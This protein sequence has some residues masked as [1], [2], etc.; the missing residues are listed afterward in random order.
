MAV[1]A[2][3][4]MNQHFVFKFVE[5]VWRKQSGESPVYDVNVPGVRLHCLHDLQ[6]R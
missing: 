5:L 6:G 4:V 3:N 2:K 1:E